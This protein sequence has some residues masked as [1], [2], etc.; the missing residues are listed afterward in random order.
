MLTLEA[1]RN[2]LAMNL[3]THEQIAQAEGLSVEEVQALAKQN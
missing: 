1:A 3:G 2:L